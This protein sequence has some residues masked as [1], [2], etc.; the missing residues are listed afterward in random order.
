MDLHLHSRLDPSLMISL[1]GE[2]S[3]VVTIETWQES[4]ATSTPLHFFIHAIPSLANSLGPKFRSQLIELLNGFG[5][6]WS[7]ILISP[8]CKPN[9]LYGPKVDIFSFLP[10]SPR[11]S[12]T[13][14]IGIRWLSKP[15]QGHSHVPH[16]IWS[17]HDYLNHNQSEDFFILKRFY[18]PPWLYYQG[19]HERTHTA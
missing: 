17:L 6:H 18:S 8:L 16:I 1:G 3:W 5:V 14:L 12:N 19:P 4:D 9:L 15:N 2:F 13:W 10:T 11:I 7:W